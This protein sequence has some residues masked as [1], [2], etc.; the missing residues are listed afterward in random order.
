MLPERP[1]VKYW[2]QQLLNAIHASHIS[3]LCSIVALQFLGFGAFRLL[4]LKDE[5]RRRQDHSFSMGRL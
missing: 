4:P 1:P 2:E 5:R 3:L